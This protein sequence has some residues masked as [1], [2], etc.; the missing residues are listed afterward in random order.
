MQDLAVSSRSV[1]EGV[2]A[3]RQAADA[4]AKQRNPQAVDYTA[5]D[6]V[7]SY[8]ITFARA[9][10]ELANAFISNGQGHPTVVSAC[11]NV[12]SEMAKL[13]SLALA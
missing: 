8:A 6:Q 7:R 10:K 4:Q 9:N 2:M 3:V 13:N 11:Q 1:I 12:K 5:T